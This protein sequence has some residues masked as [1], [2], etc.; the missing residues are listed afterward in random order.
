VTR[1]DG[2]DAAALAALTGA[3]RLELHERVTSTQDVVHAL[4]AR[5]EPAGTCVLAEEQTAGR[6]RAGRRWVSPPGRGLWLSVL[7]RP[8]AAIAGG[9]VA[10]RA[11]LATAAA[12][13]EAAPELA[14]RLKWPND[15]ILDGRKAG[16]ILCE[17]RWSGEAVGWVAVGVGLNVLGPVDRALTDAATALS[18]HAPAVA[19]AA[20]LAALVPRL[21]PLGGRGPGLTAEEQAAFLAL[22]WTPPGEPEP[23]ALEADGTLVVRHGDGR[24]ARRRDA[25]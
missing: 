10:L 16:G 9:V 11:G 1:W 23:V 13:R 4:A 8:A 24:I 15:V 2:F 25:A 19:R 22:A 7:L 21:L 5:G 12:L 6:G 3:P 17:A 18:D 14:T 20:V